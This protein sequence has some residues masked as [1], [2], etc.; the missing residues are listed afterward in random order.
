MAGL[1]DDCNCTPLSYY[2]DK[3]NIDKFELKEKR[4]TIASIVAGILFTVGWWII[5]DCAIVYPSNQQFHKA[6]LTIGIFGSLSL[7][8]VNSISNA[9]FRGDVYG[10]G[11]CI[12]AMTS[13]IILFLSFLFVFGSLISGAWVMIAQYLIPNKSPIY[14]GVALFLQTL[15]IFTSTLIFKFGRSEE[16]WS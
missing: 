2:Y 4:N 14:P 7:I 9:R 11:G 13:R 12:G 10:S 3:L 1:F 5:I 16:Q 6:F 8:F 15:F